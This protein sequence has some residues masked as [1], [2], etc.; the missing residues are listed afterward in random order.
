MA[1]KKPITAERLRELM[2]YDPHTGEFTRLKAVKGNA[3]GCVVGYLGP[4]G[5]WSIMIDYK[6]YYGHRLAHLFMTSRWPA[7]KIDHRDGNRSNNSWSNL[8]P[9][10]D[11]ENALNSGVRKDNTSGRK[12]VSFYKAT[13]KWGAYIT[14]DGCRKHLGYFN[15]IEDAA[16]AYADAAHKY[17]GEFARTA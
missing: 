8:R 1:D 15:L 7:R 5:Y 9:A 14:V 17:H 12:G 10:N 16:A 6:M 3:A 4:Q 13:A 11:T 2:H